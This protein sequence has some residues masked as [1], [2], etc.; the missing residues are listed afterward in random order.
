MQLFFIIRHYT[1]N[2]LS[3][4]YI[5]ITMATNNDNGS[6]NVESHRLSKFNSDGKLVKKVRVVGRDSLIGP[7]ALHSV[8]MARSL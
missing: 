5:Q 7:M 6:H 4:S 2:L 3:T 8:R 1:L